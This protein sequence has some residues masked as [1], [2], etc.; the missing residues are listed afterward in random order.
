MGALLRKLTIEQWRAIDEEY[1]D[2]RLNDYRVLWM[3]AVVAL[4]ILVARNYGNPKSILAVPA[5]KA[6]FATLPYPTLW[7]KLY[8]ASFKTVVY[9]LMPAAVI[10][11]V[12]RD[13]LVEH[14]LRWGRGKG[15]WKL[16]LGM[17]VL[18][19]PM[20][21][22]A[23]FSG[24]FLRAYP[25]YAQA[26]ETLTQLLIWEAGYGYQFFMTELFFR[27]LV[28]FSLARFM[29]SAAIFVVMVPYA[30]IHMSKPMPEAVGSMITGIALGTIALRTRSIY[31]GV[32]VHCGVAWA[33]DLFALSRKGQLP[34]GWS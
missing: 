24:S 4:S 5:A 7:P 34:S 21:Y 22:V 33:M 11:L 10:K 8:W 17:L 26:G 6:W 15:T 31:G 2:R 23:S 1:L 9:F 20:A 28:L 12:Y 30:L 25:K 27:G 16:Y 3:L 13:P 14:G 19:I 29:G 32:A 18:V